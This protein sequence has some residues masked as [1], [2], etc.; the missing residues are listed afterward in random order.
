MSS[1]G[2]IQ[3]ADLDPQ[4][5]FVVYPGTA[6]FPLDDT[7]DAIGVVALVSAL[8]SGKVMPTTES[9]ADERT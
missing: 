1:A 9:G 7:T 4:R 5:R 2:F 8:Q 6:H 3:C